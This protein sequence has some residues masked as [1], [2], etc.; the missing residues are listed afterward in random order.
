MPSTKIKKLWH[1][2]R[3]MK[4]VFKFLKISWTTEHQALGISEISVQVTEAFVKFNH[5]IFQVTSSN[6]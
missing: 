2:A 4:K 3:K 5:F 6:K 1:M